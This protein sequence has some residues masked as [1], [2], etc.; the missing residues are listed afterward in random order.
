[1]VTSCLTV[2]CLDGQV[3]ACMVQGQFP[4]V[5]TL[6]LL[7]GALLLASVQR[8]LKSHSKMLF[9]LSIAWGNGRRKNSLN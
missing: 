4:H 6:Q 8:Q 3:H 5:E 7:W 2:M 1:M 9:L